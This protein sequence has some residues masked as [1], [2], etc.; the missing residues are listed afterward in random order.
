MGS[1]FSTYHLSIGEVILFV[2][3]VFVFSISGVIKMSRSNPYY[4]SYFNNR[5]AFASPFSDSLPL[6]PALESKECIFNR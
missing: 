2:F 6:F 4:L 1:R 3:S 5:V